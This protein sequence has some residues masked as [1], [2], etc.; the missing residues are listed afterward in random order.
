MELAYLQ[1]IILVL[2][3]LISL[4]GLYLPL[5]WLRFKGS[6]WCPTFCCTQNANDHQE[7]RSDHQQELDEGTKQN[8]LSRQNLSWGN[9]VASGAFF[10]LCFLH[11]LPQSMEKWNQVFISLSQ[12]HQNE[13]STINSSEKQMMKESQPQHYVT[14]IAAFLAFIGFTLMLYLEVYCSQL[15]QDDKLPSI[16]L[17]RVRFQF[18]L[19]RFI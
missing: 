15:A 3:F 18:D 1:L 11:L 4:I 9:C 17:T 16:T 14:S 7:L 10:G 5:I 13:S 2:T 8:E 19:L 12:H 6:D